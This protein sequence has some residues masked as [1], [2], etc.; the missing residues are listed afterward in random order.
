VVFDLALDDANNVY[1]SGDFS[2]VVDFDPGAGTATLSATAPSTY[3]TFVWEL[4][5][6]GGYEWAGAMGT[7][8]DHS[9]YAIDVDASGNIYTAGRWSGSG[10]FDPGAGTYNLTSSAYGGYLVKLTQTSSLAGAASA[11]TTP[12]ISELAEAGATRRLQRKSVDSVLA[13]M[14]ELGTSVWNRPLEDEL[15]LELAVMRP[16]SLTLS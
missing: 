1:V 5:A 9:G 3:I 8:G 11:S 2:G 15:L 16:R 6:N 13:G 12:S 14:G 4:D 10:D 7:Q